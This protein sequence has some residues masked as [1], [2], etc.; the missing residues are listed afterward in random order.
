MS[1]SGSFASD[2]T[3]GAHPDVL[4]AMARVNTGHAPAY[5]YDEHTERTRLLLRR[6]LGESAQPFF[7]FGGTG[8]NVTAL[9]AVLLPQDCIITA[10]TAHIQVDEC[11][12]PE[13]H[14]G[15]KL[16]PVETPDGKLTPALVEPHIKGVGFEHHAQPRVISISQSTEYGTVYTPEELEALSEFAHSRRLLL[17]VDGARIANAA[18]SLNVPLKAITSDAGIDLLSLGITKN[19]AV[20]AEAVVFFRE[21]PA[22]RFKYVRKQGMQL[23]SKMRFVAAQFEALFTDDLWRRNAAHANAMARRLADGVRG[24]PGVT[25]TQQVEANAVFATL[26]KNRI[27]PLQEKFFFYVWDEATSEVRWMTSWDTSPEEVDA[28]VAEVGSGKW[29]VGSGA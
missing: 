2:N 6:A 24:A 18:A 21:E 14:I 26:P 10:A 8:A 4:A 1:H 3:A 29:E 28:F 27:A 23:P 9:D 20:G 15:C 13:R 25:I 7:V 17:H 12:A 16:L 11:G 19:G 22:K 5:G